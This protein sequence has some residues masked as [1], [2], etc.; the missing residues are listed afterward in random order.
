MGGK[1]SQAKPRKK[2]RKHVTHHCTSAKD[3]RC[4]DDLLY[5]MVA[6]K[7]LPLQ[8]GNETNSFLIKFSPR[9]FLFR[10]FLFEQPSWSRNEIKERAAT[11]GSLVVKASAWAAVKKCQICNKKRNGEAEITGRR[12]LFLFGGKQNQ[13]TPTQ[14]PTFHV[15]VVL[16]LDRHPS[17]APSLLK[18][19]SA[20]CFFLSS[21]A[22]CTEGKKVRAF[23]DMNEELRAGVNDL[24]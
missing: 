14:G 11:T 16:S 19:W 21:L 2:R 23:S 7:L 10:I 1:K 8:K 3:V 17:L 5:A 20:S 15:L 9:V 18:K 13:E 24:Q 6:A 12:P 22:I 4:S